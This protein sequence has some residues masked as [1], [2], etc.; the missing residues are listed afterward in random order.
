L[1]NWFDRAKIKIPYSPT[2]SLFQDRIIRGDNGNIRTNYTCA[3]TFPNYGEVQER[4]V[5]MSLSLI[6]TFNP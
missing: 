6:L 2:V 3:K 4:F 5:S 1:T